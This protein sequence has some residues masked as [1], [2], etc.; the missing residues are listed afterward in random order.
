MML[1]VSVDRG[2]EE[3]DLLIEDELRGVVVKWGGN[4]EIVVFWN[5]NG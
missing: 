5:L 1:G 4:Q 3:E 2:W